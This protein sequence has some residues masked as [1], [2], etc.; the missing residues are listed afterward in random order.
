MWE[1]IVLDQ[2][3]KFCLYWNF[4]EVTC[5]IFSSYMYAYMAAFGVTNA[6][7]SLNADLRAVDIFFFIIF[8]ISIVMN[9]L[10][11]FVP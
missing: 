11:S 1:L 3:S 6:D 10:R 4:F 5:C 9:F 8:T 2:N 7:G